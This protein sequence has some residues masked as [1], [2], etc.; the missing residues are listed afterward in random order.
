MKTETSILFTE[1]V[2]PTRPY[3]QKELVEN[4]K[5]FLQKLG[6]SQN[7]AQHNQC[8]HTYFVKDGGNKDKELA[9]SETNDVGN[10]SVCWKI[11][12]T[13]KREGMREKAENFVNLYNQEFQNN[14]LHTERLSYYGTTIER[15][16]YIWLYKEM[17]DFKNKNKKN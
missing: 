4:R 5:F 6:L 13:P 9:A 16:F 12:Q 7:Y 14:I 17:Y 15:I 3:S 2:P 1:W 11:R 8:G 10:C